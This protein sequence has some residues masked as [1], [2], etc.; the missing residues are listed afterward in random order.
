MAQ[1]YPWTS[2]F[3]CLL[4][5]GSDLV[6]SQVCPLMFKRWILWIQ[7]VHSHNQ[8][9]RQSGR[10]L[11][12]DALCFVSIVK[13]SLPPGH[14]WS[15]LSVILTAYKQAGIAISGMF[16]SYRRRQPANKDKFRGKKWFR[17]RNHQCLP[18][19]CLNPIP[20]VWYG[21]TISFHHSLYV[22][23]H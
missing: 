12:Q 18:Q 23:L 6:C 10:F 22:K 11:L 13:E 20:L 9:R 15:R 2:V 5:E 7:M 14:L 4:P 8:V 19:K 1:W 17:V 3:P 21:R 16:C